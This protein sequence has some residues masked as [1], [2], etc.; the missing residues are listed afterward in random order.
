[1]TKSLPNH[2]FES[3]WEREQIESTNI[4]QTIALPHPMQLISNK[5]IVL[6]AVIS[7]GVKWNEN[8][9]GHFVFLLSIQKKVYKNT[10]QLYDLLLSFI[11]DE[12][13]QQ[14]MLSY[15]EFHTFIDQLK[16]LEI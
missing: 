12:N 1:M 6:F 13:L 7:H 16:Q 3:V 2:F 15:P 4:N 11:N 10:E 5:S 14:T 8:S 9:Y